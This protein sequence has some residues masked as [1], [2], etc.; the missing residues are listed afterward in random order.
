MSIG[1][2]N[3]HLLALI[4]RQAEG[5]LPYA[6]IFEP[7]FQQLKQGKHRRVLSGIPEG[8]RLYRLLFLVSLGLVQQVTHRRVDYFALTPDSLDAVRRRLS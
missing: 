8:E 2:I 6:H 7:H 3:Q 5:R 4:S 1:A